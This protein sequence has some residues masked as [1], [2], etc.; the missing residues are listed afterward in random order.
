LYISADD[1]VKHFEKGDGR[2]VLDYALIFKKWDQFSNDWEQMCLQSKSS[3]FLARR[4]GELHP[5]K[6]NVAFYFL[7]KNEDA[8][9]N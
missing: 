8:K 5:A 2:I 4:F 9:A 3:D 6:N 7:Y 1:S